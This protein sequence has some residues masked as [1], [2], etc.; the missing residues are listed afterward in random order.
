MIVG[1]AFFH[2]AEVEDYQLDGNVLLLK[3]N[4]RTF[5][6]TLILALF[7]NVNVF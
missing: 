7:R 1:I 5:D 2:R 4:K 3:I 6:V